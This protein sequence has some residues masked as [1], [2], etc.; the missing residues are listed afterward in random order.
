KCGDVPV[1]LL[2]ALAGERGDA[3]R[4]IAQFHDEPAAKGAALLRSAFAGSRQS[5]GGRFVLDLQVASTLGTAGWAVGAYS[6]NGS[7]ASGWEYPAGA[8]VL[9]ISSRSPGVYHAR[10]FSAAQRAGT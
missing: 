3:Q 8:R 6:G 4:R 5:A 7:R 10:F 9:P 1:H 2:V